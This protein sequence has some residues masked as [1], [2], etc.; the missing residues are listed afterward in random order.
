[1]NPQLM[2]H[3]TKLFYKKNSLPIYVTFFVTNRCNFKCQHCFYSEEL[4]RPT[5]E[6]SLAEVSTLSQSMGSIL[7]MLYSGGEPFLR[8]DLAEITKVF[9]NQN[10]IR[11]LSIP[12]NGS[13]LRETI[14][15]V[16]NI[17][18]S[19]PRLTLVLHFS[20][21]GLK[22]THERIRETRN[23]FGEAIQTFT[24]I[25]E[26]KQKFKRLKV[27]FTITFNAF[28]QNEIGEIYTY[29]KSLGPDSVGIN[30]VRGSAKNPL[31]QN[32]ELEKY[33]A[34]TRE[35][36]KDLANSVLPGYG[37][38]LGALA[39]YKYSIINRLARENKFI[40][41]C[42]SS[43]L[44]CVIY[45]NGDVYPCEMLP[46]TKIGNVREF[47]LNFRRLWESKKNK[48]I[49]EWV[50]K[51]KCFCTHECNVGC[52]VTFNLKHL[53]AIGLDILRSGLRS[54]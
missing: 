49:A 44:A 43:R 9:Y 22:D 32:I 10:K 23:S 15:T 19:C 41:P 25:K 4:N 39:S 21:D 18:E 52:N 50:V 16:T 34:I 3:A 13:L 51:S 54:P 29:L 11:Y 7:V 47:Q 24:R 6:L 40:S 36:Q 30:L 8:K 27:G 2:R 28:N 17:C 37:R 33:T 26:L 38:Y 42:Y 48:A 46:E 31:T 53:S 35:V 12:T 5:Q 20:I 45:P 14:Q 1:M